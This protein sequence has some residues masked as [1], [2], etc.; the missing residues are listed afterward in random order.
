MILGVYLHFRNSSRAQ[1]QNRDDYDHDSSSISTLDQVVKQWMVAAAKCD[2]TTLFKMLRDDPRLAKAKD[3]TSG[4]TALHWACKHGN[5][6][7]V[8]LLVCEKRFSAV[9]LHFSIVCLHFRRASTEPTPTFGLMEATLR[10]TWHVN[11]IIKK[12]L[13][14]WSKLMELILTCVTMLEKRLDSTWLLLGMAC[15]T[16]QMT[17]LGKKKKKNWALFS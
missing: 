16:C 6:D 8:K 7:L 10:C 14:S 2:Y 3:F 15:I 1:S 5:L 9:C 13:T 17:L 11:L 4:Y 12:S